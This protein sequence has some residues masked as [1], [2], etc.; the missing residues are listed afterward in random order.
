M[1]CRGPIYWSTGSVAASERGSSRS[2]GS[3]KAAAP[4]P[5]GVQFLKDRD[6]LISSL[7]TLQKELEGTPTSYKELVQGLSDDMDER[8]CDWSGMPYTQE[9]MKKEIADLA[10]ETNDELETSKKCTKHNIGTHQQKLNELEGR[11]SA[12]SQHFTD[13]QMCANVQ[14]KK[15]QAKHTSTYQKAYQ[16]NKRFADRL[17]KGRFKDTH[18]KWLAK[19]IISYERAIEDSVLLPPCCCHQLALAATGQHPLAQENLQ[20]VGGS[21]LIVCFVCPLAE[22]SLWSQT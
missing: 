12:L 7:Q 4:L 19:M 8:E 20:M 18:A 22:C 11:Q 17:Q 5:P 16:E 1:A 14:I 9:E 2:V 13:F 6:A 21:V 15:A 3:A 10:K